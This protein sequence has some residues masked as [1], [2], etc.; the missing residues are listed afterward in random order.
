M[1]S[2]FSFAFFLSRTGAWTNGPEGSFLHQLFFLLLM[3]SVSVSYL[4]ETPLWLGGAA[5][6]ME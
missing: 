2:V 1:R 5:C 6:A 3:P 4:T